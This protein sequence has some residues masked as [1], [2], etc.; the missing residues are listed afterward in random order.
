MCQLL[1]NMKFLKE[2]FYIKKKNTKKGT[3]G[4]N[5]IFQAQFLSKLTPEIQWVMFQVSGTNFDEVNKTA[6]QNCALQSLD[7]VN[8]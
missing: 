8:R 1:K 2:L 3:H 6:C 7:T 4:L 5:L